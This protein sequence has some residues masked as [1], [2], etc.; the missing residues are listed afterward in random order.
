MEPGDL[1]LPHALQAG[2]PWITYLGLPA[3]VTGVPDKLP[4]PQ[5]RHSPASRTSSGL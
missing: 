2:R 5:T 1:H 3:L 4:W